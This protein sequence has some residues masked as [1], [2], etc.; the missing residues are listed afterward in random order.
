MY[1]RPIDHAPDRGW[2][3]TRFLSPAIRRL[4]SQLHILD[5]G[6][7]Q[8]RVPEQLRAEGHRVIAVD[9]VAP[10]TPHPDRLV[11][12]LW[13]SALGAG[14]FDIAFA[15]QV[16]EHLPRPVPYLHAML[17]LTRTGGLVAI[18]TDMHVAERERVP[19]TDWWYV[20]PPLHCSFFR[21]AT[22]EYLLADTPH[23]IVHRTPKCVMIEKGTLGHPGY[24]P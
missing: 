18:H 10:D 16:F 22:F 13:S 20:M 5:F 14:Q 12:S 15:F 1:S 3:N 7:G 21:H 23:R 19:F 8:S 4:G 6:T 9:T 17:R 11:G 24:E 2:A